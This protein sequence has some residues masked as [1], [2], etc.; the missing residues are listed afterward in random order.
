MH[1]YFN[2]NFKDLQLRDGQGSIYA[3]GH[4]QHTRPRRVSSI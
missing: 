3:Y 2:S 1:D 4:T